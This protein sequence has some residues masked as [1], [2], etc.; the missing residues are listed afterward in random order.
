MASGPPLLNRSRRR[1]L[2]PTWLGTGASKNE[3]WPGLPVRPSFFAPVTGLAPPQQTPRPSGLVQAGRRIGEYLAA[4]LRDA[5]CV[6]ELRRQLAVARHGSPAVWQNFH[7]RLA[8][9]DHR[10]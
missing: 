10:L 8:E 7:V 1:L 2:C 3:P 4:G 5:N 6:L 9:V